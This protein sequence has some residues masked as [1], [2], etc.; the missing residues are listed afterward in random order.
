MV[1]LIFYR[2][3]LFF[4]VLFF[5]Y[6]LLLL[7]FLLLLFHSLWRGAEGLLSLSGQLFVCIVWALG[8]V[9]L[10]V[11]LFVVFCRFLDVVSYY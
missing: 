3:F 7:L 11:V 1:V 6:L 9:V 10:H 5:I 2:F 8:L 4:F